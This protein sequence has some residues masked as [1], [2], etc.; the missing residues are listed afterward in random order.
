[1]ETELE[2]KFLDIEPDVLRAQL[3]K[4]GAALVYAQRMMKRKNFDYPDKRLEKI[5]GWIRLRDE[6]DKITLAYKRVI[7][8]TLEGTKEICVNVNDFDKATNLLIAIGLDQKSYQETKREKWIYNDVEITIDTWP[9]I[10]TFVEFEGSTEEKLRNA[11]DAF[12][13]DWSNALHGSVEVA[14]QRSYDVSE[15]EIDSWETITFIPIPDW[16]KIRRKIS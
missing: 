6:G 14:Y 3:A 10:P 4:Q 16:L 9:W 2:A 13:F 1:M 15:E 7:D 8:R 5:G 12:G 11:V